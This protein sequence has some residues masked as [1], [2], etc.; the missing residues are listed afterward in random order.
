[1]QLLSLFGI[2]VGNICNELILLTVMETILLQVSFLHLKKIIIN[3]NQ[4]KCV[5]EK[6][7]NEQIKL[8]N[9]RKNAIKNKRHNKTHTKE[10]KEKNVSNIL[11]MY[12]FCVI[13]F[14]S[15]LKVDKKIDN[16][17]QNKK[18]Y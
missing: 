12:L 17:K 7:N 9:C 18:N 2:I 5:G 10:K 11:N 15:S 3:L 13:I 8:L 14:N 1:L 6:N 4:N 16:N